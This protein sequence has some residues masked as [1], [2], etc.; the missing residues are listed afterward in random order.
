MRKLSK[1][2]STLLAVVMLMSVVLC[3]PFTVSA[4]TSGDYEYTIRDDG[5]AEITKYKGNQTGVVI[6]SKI[7]GYSITRIGKFAFMGSKSLENVVFPESIKYIDYGAFTAC[8]NLKSVTFSDSDNYIDIAR[9]AFYECPNLKSVTLP[10]KAC[11]YDWA[12]GYNYNEFSDKKSD[13]FTIYGYTGSDAETYAIN[14]GF[15]FVSLG[16]TTVN[17]SHTGGSE[18]YDNNYYSFDEIYENSG[19]IAEFY[20]SDDYGNSENLIGSCKISRYFSSDNSGWYYQGYCENINMA[21]GCIRKFKDGNGRELHFNGSSSDDSSGWGI[22]GMK[23]YIIVEVSPLTANITVTLKLP[24]DSEYYEPVQDYDILTYCFNDKI[25]EFQIN[26]Y[27]YDGTPKTPGVKFFGNDGTPYEF[28]EGKDYTLTCTNNVNAGTA[29]ATIKGMGIYAGTTVTKNFTIN[30]ADQDLLANITTTNLKCGETAQIV[31][32]G[33]GNITYS[34]SDESVAQ[35]SSKGVV[36]A[37]GEGYTVIT[38]NAAGNNNYNSDTERIIVFVSGTANP[39]EPTKPVQI[40]GDVNGDGSVTV[41]DA[42]MLQKY[43]AGLTSLS[44]EQL[45]LADTNGDGS[46]TI[47]DATQ[48]QKYLAGLVTELG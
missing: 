4:L 39:T 14:N 22:A 6:P 19:L 3:A 16:E 45:T 28:I 38:I 20:S 40:I 44:D 5:T 46:V 48:I 12:F 32:I 10:E 26:N 29:T 41:L 8:T 15:R 18:P 43:I 1:A 27:I 2:I 21:D 33:E 36:K 42:T 13:G 47:L 25:P 24:E 17:D 34:S 35:V 30:K 37:V 7:S 9:F 11:I 23:D 31:A